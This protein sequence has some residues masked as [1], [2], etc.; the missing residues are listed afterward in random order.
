[1][2]GLQL[3]DTQKVLVTH[4]EN[5]SMAPM[6]ERFFI[7]NSTAIDLT[8]LNE[9]P[10][11]KESLSGSSG[12][13]KPILSQAGF[14]KPSDRLKEST[15][16]LTSPDYSTPDYSVLMTVS[17]RN[18]YFLHRAL[19]SLRHQYW[20]NLELIAVCDH[21]SLID[22]VEEFCRDNGIRHET[23]LVPTTFNRTNKFNR[24]VEMS[25]GSWI[26]VLDC[27]DELDG[28][29]LIVL[30]EC[31]KRFPQQMYFCTAHQQIDID[32]NPLGVIKNDPQENT[33]TA[34]A[35]KFR[36]RHLWGFKRESMPY[37]APSLKHHFICED[38]HFFAMNAVRGYFPLCIPFSLYRY[39]RHSCQLTQYEKAEIKSMMISIQTAVARYVDGADNLILMKSAQLARDAEQQQK[40]LLEQ[41]D[42]C[43]IVF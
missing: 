27:D 14:P 21:V 19:E 2:N 12:T 30:N 29:A 25:R 37:L 26:I 31:L 40:L 4:S 28:G 7:G 11:K 13:M 5:A 17:T 3:L 33:V 38:Y 35:G 24:G 23:A 15:Q 20:H 1:M 34:L 39:R 32:G 16:T 10:H 42:P 36:Q 6:P 8:C 41:V 9:T 43:G 22:E 18:C